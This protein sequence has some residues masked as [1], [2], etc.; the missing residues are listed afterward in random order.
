[1]KRLAERRKHTR[2]QVPVLSAY[3]I[4]PRSGPRSPV[5][6]NIIDIGMGGISFRYVANEEEPYQS[7]HLDILL[8]DGSFRLDR[9]P[10][11]AVTSDFEVEEQTSESFAMRRCGVKFG[12]LTDG[13]KSDLR[14]FIQNHTTPSTEA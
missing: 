9:V 11:G 1:M 14:Y 4:V 2:Y 12:D 5:V 6:G 3:V 13:Q 10:I 8:P 7:S